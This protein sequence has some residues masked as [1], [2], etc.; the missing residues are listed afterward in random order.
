MLLK[1]T[2]LASR[3]PITYSQWACR[4]DDVD[5]VISTSAFHGEYKIPITFIF[6]K[7]RA[8]PF[9]VLSTYADIIGAWELALEHSK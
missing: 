8:E 3:N 1:F 5:S 4:A 7:G 9:E 2:I 6:Q